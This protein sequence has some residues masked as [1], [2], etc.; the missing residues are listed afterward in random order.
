MDYIEQYIDQYFSDLIPADHII[1]VPTSAV[2][3][4][5]TVYVFYKIKFS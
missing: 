1:I 2:I 5:T 4:R 3:V